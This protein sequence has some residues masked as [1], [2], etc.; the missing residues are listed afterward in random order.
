MVTCLALLLPFSAQAQ[1]LQFFPPDNLIPPLLADPL[2]P[3]MFV[4]KA[5]ENRQIEARLGGHWDLTRWQPESPFLGIARLSSGLTGLANM[6]LDM[7]PVG[8]KPWWGWPVFLSQRY[9]Y[10][11]VSGDFAFGGYL[12]AE[13]PFEAVTLRYRLQAI[14]LSA[15]LGDSFFIEGEGRLSRAPLDYSRNYWQFLVDAHLP[16][17]L[18]VYLE[19]G[20]LTWYDRD[21]GTNLST[22]LFHA[23]AEYRHPRPLLH[24]FYPFLAA[25]ARYFDSVE[26]AGPWG[27]AM[28]TGLR[29]SS[30]FGPGL[31]FF[32]GRYAGPTWRGQFFGEAVMEW[33]AGVR[34]DVR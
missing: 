29:F 18:R 33:H 28:H 17:G 11:L 26:P 2:E 1:H 6:Q 16:S 20:Y 9:R 24:Y 25:D 3:A 27:L 19:P 10:D 14:H 23:G 5:L 30:W 8:R 13:Q 15:H 21:L 34:V 32:I 4:A 31:D 12:S 7:V 22:L